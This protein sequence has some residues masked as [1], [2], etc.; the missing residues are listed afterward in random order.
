MITE[1]KDPRGSFVH[2]ILTAFMLAATLSMLT[3]CS[4][5]TQ[6]NAEQNTQQ[7]VAIRPLENSTPLYMVDGKKIAEADFKA[8][9]PNSIESISVWKDAKAIQKFGEEG[10]NGVIDVVTKK[11]A[12]VKD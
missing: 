10:K 4:K 5:N 9:D 6:K 12:P 8:I 11:A 1:N 7:N 3:F 2:P